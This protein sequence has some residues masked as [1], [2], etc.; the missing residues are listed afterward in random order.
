MTIYTL[1]YGRRAQPMATVKP[2]ERYPEMYRI[3]YHDGTTSDMV[4]LT[5]AKDAA[6]TWVRRKHPELSS[7]GFRWNAAKSSSGGAPMR[8]T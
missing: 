2:D 3:H 4:N 1:H 5:R 7:G 6:R 8:Q